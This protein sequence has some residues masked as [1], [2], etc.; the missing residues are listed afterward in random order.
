MYYFQF[1]GIPFRTLRYSQDRFLKIQMLPGFGNE[2][3]HYR[4]AGDGVESKHRV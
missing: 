3:P 1:E 4:G 2:S